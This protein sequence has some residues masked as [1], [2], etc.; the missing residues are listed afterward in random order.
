MNLIF[1]MA[2]TVPAPSAR[3]AHTQGRGGAS[4]SKMEGQTASGRLK[5]PR[6]RKKGKTRMVATKAMT[7]KINKKTMI[8]SLPHLKNPKLMNH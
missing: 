3:T 7:R 6:M 4:Q 8:A 2:H 1:A 5:E